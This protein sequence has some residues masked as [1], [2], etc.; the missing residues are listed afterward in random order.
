MS[1][2]LIIIT[3][4]TSGIG[5]ETAKQFS[6]KGYPLLL[7]GRNTQSLLELNL[8]NAMVSA[9]DVT[10]LQALQL[11]IKEAEAVYGPADALINNAGVMLL[12]E[13]DKQNPEEWRRMVEVNLLGVMNGAHAVLSGM[14]ER[15]H[16]TL[17]NI[18]S[19]AGFKTF[20]NHAAYTSTKF[21]VHGFSE[22]IREEGAPHNVRVMTI[23]PGAVETPLLSH[24]T[25]QQIK[26]DYQQW[27]EEMGG[28]LQAS[29]VARTI[30]FAYE[31]PQSVNIREIQ[32]A[33]TQ[34]QA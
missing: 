28:V 5:L 8:A 2:P 23:S 18:S 32:L 7:L 21:A 1:K 22:S 11:A 6:E 19:I 31:Q 16:G 14:K 3:G 33:T 12:S 26:A 4:A 10:D 25:N 29:D 9:V 24:T 30:L 13:F 27:K 17:I 34:Q 15:K 20:P